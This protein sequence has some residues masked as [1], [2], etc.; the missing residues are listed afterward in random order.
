MQV[1][2]EGI[3]GLDNPAYIALDNIEFEN[4]G[5]YSSLPIYSL[6]ADKR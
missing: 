2:F 3:S 1:I 4:C 6:R 5:E